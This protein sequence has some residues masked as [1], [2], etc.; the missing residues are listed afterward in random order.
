MTEELSFEERAAR[1]RSILAA[2][3]RLADARDPL[4]QEARAR[5]PAVT[6]LSEAGV[7]LALSRHLET[8]V[9][10]ADLERLIARAGSAPRVHVVL[11]ANVFAGAVRAIA[12]A[13]VTAP[14][15]IVRASTRETVMAPLLRR[16]LREAD[17]R[18]DFD[19]SS[20]L[21]AKPGDEVHVY[22]RRETIDAVG[23]AM[24]RGV[25]IRAHGPGIGIAVIDAHGGVPPFAAEL[26]SWDVVAFDQRG[27]L[28]PRL[29]FVAGSADEVDAFA[30]GVS[31]ALE[32][33][34]RE[35]PRGLISADERSEQTLYRNTMTA[36]GKFYAGSSFSVGVDLAPRG[37]PLPPSGRNLHVARVVDS[38]DLIRLLA[39]L[40]ASIT[41][42]GH[43]APGALAVH[44][45][46]L[47]C[48]ARSLPL[49]S[50]QTPPL[51]GP[52]D[53]REMV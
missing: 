53:L 45:I 16:A 3:R 44:A 4:G 22:G 10:P 31:E 32:R 24:P 26:L 19:L 39:P 46:A 28:S 51:D 5:L 20:T 52:V 15:V 38:D 50:M 48:G 33:R 41:C 12:F 6:G 17:D 36:I 8:N 13:S 40:R 35:V 49:G 27:C 47:A 14:S 29:A 30:V 11:S 18:F 21:A 34:E 43:V 2:A 37:V 23:A 1:V 7:E 25:R 42:V 9:S